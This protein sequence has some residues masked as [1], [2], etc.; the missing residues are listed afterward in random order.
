[1]EKPL[2]LGLIEREG[3]GHIETRVGKVFQ[4]EVG[5]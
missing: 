4:T 3:I 5:L 1:M 2:A